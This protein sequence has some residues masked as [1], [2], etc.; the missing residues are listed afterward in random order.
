MRITGLLLTLLSITLQGCGKVHADVAEA[1]RNFDFHDGAEAHSL[2]IRGSVSW[3]LVRGANGQWAGGQES[4]LPLDSPIKA[5]HVPSYPALPSGFPDL[6]S[7]GGVSV[8]AFQDEVL[9][10]CGRSETARCRKAILLVKGT[11]LSGGLAGSAAAV[12][13]NYFFWLPGWEGVAG[14][15]ENLPLVL[16]EF[17][18]PDE[19]HAVSLSHLGEMQAFHM[20]MATGHATEHAT[21]RVTLEYALGL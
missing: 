3:N 12:S 18:I 9:S 17:T 5:V 1:G 16:H 13:G 11:V 6:I 2:V 19:A 21:V 10:V 8:T 7:L 20:G 14:A 15:R 4:P